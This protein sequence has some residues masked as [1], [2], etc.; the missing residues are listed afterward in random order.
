MQAD[1]SESILVAE[2]LEFCR[3]LRLTR[4]P[5]GSLGCFHESVEAV[6]HD[7]LYRTK[8]ESANKSMLMIEPITQIN[9]YIY[10]QDDHAYIARR[11]HRRHCSLYKARLGLFCPE[12]P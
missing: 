7:A 12:F 6:A 4:H 2:S 8:R 10:S 11:H 1:L 9:A 3:L 5:Y